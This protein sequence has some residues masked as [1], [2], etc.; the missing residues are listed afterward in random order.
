MLRTSHKQHLALL[1]DRPHAWL[2][3]FIILLCN[4]YGLLDVS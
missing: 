4:E 3:P 1:L 2:L